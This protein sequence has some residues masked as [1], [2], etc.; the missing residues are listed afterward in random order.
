MGGTPEQVE[1]DLAEGITVQADTLEEL[2]AKTDMPVEN[3]LATVARYN[4]MCAKGHD[5]DCLKE[6][7]WLQP[8]DTPPFYAAGIGAAITGTGGLTKLGSNGLTLS[9]TNTYSGLTTVNGGT[10]TL[11]G[12]LS[13]SSVTVANGATFT[14]K[15]A[16]PEGLWLLPAESS[17]S[18]C[19]RRP[20]SIRRVVSSS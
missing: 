17:S 9:N 10:L 5:D 15:T 13:N 16:P 19:W 18:P 12:S 11:N 4:E 1:K 3:L 7:V 2:A 14:E 6:P 20:G 8:V